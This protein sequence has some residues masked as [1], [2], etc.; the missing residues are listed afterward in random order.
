MERTQM[1]AQQL[2]S[3]QVGVIESIFTK[4]NFSRLTGSSE[5]PERAYEFIS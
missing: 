5:A 1:I 4:Q 2:V 3:F